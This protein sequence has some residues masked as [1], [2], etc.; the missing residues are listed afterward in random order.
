MKK[1][2]LDG[3]VIEG[4]QYN[5]K[6]CVIDKEPEFIRD[7]L[8]SFFYTVM[9]VVA[10]IIYMHTQNALAIMCAMLGYNLFVVPYFGIFGE[11]KIDQFNLSKKAEKKFMM[12]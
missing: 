8:P 3:S 5:G 7:I 12:D 2:W 11:C 10:H 6:V 9:I 1:I 4:T